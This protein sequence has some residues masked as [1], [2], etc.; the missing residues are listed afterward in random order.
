[1]ALSWVAVNANDGSIIEDLPTLR[2][3]GALKQTLMRYETQTANLPMGDAPSSWRQATRPGAVF[4]V[5]LSEPEENEPRGLPL[6]GGMIIRRT[7]KVG[8]GVDVSLVTAEGYFDR[9][10][11][12]DETFNATAQN[13]IV[14]TMAEKYAKTGAKRGLPLRVQIIGGNGVLRDKNTWKDAADKT[15]YAALQDFA[16]LIGGSEW[17]VGWEWVDEQ[18]LGLVLYVGDRIGKKPPAGLGPAAQF[19]LPGAVTEAELVEGYGADEGA[20]DVMA[21]STGTEGAR[22]QSPH[23][24]VATDLRPRFEYRWTP[25]SDIKD[26]ATLTAHARRALA[27][28]KDGSLAMT[29]TAN[30]GE[31]PKLGLDWFIGDDIGFDIDALEFPDGLV[32]TARCVGWELTETTITPLIDVTAVRG[33]D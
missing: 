14:K 20:N 32:G 8:N 1:M 13:I 22:P 33:I 5:A 25:E 4:L 7:R 29:L 23:Q 9:V 27:A 16:G 21:V 19:Y 26:T 15:L 12:G 28:L 24:T 10:Y 6:W 3:S 18:K 17:T 11:V 2:V 30:R 31:A